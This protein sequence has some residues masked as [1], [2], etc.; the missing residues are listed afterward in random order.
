MSIR[1]PCC[2]A[3]LDSALVIQELSLGSKISKDLVGPPAEDGE[4]GEG[5]EEARQRGRERGGIG[6]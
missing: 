3:F 2:Q 4:R 5:G 1:L 6:S